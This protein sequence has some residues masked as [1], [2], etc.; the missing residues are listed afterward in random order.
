M[1][2]S[3]RTEL[4]EV[5]RELSEFCPDLRLGQLI[6]NLSYKAR[7]MANESIWDM[8]DEELLTAARKLTESLKTREALTI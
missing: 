6:V 5:L 7:G 4:F 3:E 8:E 2:T 1:S